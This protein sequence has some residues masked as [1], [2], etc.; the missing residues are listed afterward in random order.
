MSIQPPQYNENDNYQI[1]INNDLTPDT[2]S[3]KII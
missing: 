3:K 2:W 1:E